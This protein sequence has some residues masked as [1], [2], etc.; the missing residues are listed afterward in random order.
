M[1]KLRLAIAL[2]IASV[3]AP[4][5]SLSAQLPMTDQQAQEIVR[6]LKPQHGKI[7]I[8]EADASLDLGD[9]YDFYGP[10]NA[11]MILTSLWGNPPEASEDVLGLV[12]AAGQSPLS[13][14][15][16]AV[17]T[18]DAN[19]YVSDDDAADVDFN[20]LLKQMREGEDENNEQRKSAGFSAI[21]LVGWAEQ[22]HY[23]KASHSVVWARAVRF[24]GEPVDT[25]NYDVRTLGRRG[26]L[27]V[28]LVSTMPKLAEIKTAA[29]AFAGHAA[30]NAGSR[31][32]DF[33]SSIDKEAEYGIGGLIAAGVGVAA[34]KKLGLFAILL[35]FLK[36]LAVAVA[37][38]FA[39]LRNKVMRLFRRNPPD[40]Y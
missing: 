30:F 14:A 24:E 39:A 25:L 13:D 1:T 36:P 6:F 40:E 23:D 19:G 3:I 32:E 20:D 5:G 22:P 21:H 34:A 4:L 17:I 16:G 18:Y 27:S 10:A 8:K 11:K 38:A 7:E 28:N 37:V 26:V 15:W 29:N 12:M 33:D 31:Y 2:V 9:S 35:K